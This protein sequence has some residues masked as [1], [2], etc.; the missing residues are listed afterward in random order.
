MPLNQSRGVL[1]LGRNS[2]SVSVLVTLEEFQIST[3]LKTVHSFLN[4]YPLTLTLTN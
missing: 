1:G 4:L 2:G 3:F